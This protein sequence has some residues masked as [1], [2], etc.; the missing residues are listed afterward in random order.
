VRVLH[1]DNEPKIKKRREKKKSNKC[2]WRDI[3]PLREILPDG[4]YLNCV[5]KSKT[6]SRIQG[7][8]SELTRGKIESIEE[9]RDMSINYLPWR[10]HGQ[11]LLVWKRWVT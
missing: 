8:L 6:L 9:V 4:E 5:S 10:Y 2:N 11:N 1:A 7:L 3:L